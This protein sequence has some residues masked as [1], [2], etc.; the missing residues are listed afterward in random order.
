VLQGRTQE[1][2][3]LARWV[4]EERCRVVAVLGLGDIGKT[5]VA[6]KIARTPRLAARRNTQPAYLT[7]RA[8]RL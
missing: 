1:L 2:A 5:T 3:T 4:R 6:A 8:G 7:P